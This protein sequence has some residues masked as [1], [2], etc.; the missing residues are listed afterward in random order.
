MFITTKLTL[1]L[2]L[3]FL[4]GIQGSDGFV[5]RARTGSS[6]TSLRAVSSRR[7]TLTGI[8][9]IVGSTLVGNPDE[10]AARYSSY[11]HREQDWQERK[12]KGEVNFKT[13]KDL[14]LVHEAC[15]CVHDS[16]VHRMIF[17][18]SLL[19]S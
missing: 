14:R 13:A 4:F 9:G 2:T 5:P 3:C 10:A 17:F 15:H 1:A 12:A 7:A 6:S 19:Q 18:T 8:I 16:S 11:A